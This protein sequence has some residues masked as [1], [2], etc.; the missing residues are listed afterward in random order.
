MDVFTDETIKER[1]NTLFNRCVSKY[2]MKGKSKRHNSK[3][4]CKT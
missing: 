2:Q 1:E 4:D 3:G